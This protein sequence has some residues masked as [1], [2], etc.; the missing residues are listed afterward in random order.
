MEN[1]CGINFVRE[2]VP[3]KLE[4]IEEGEKKGMVRVHAQYQDGTPY[5]DVFNTVMFAVGRQAE[6]E[7]LGLG[8]VGVTLNPKNKKISSS[9]KSRKYENQ[10]EFETRKKYIK[11]DDKSERYETVYME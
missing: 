5:E 2:C 11:N 8:A 6:T 1:K 9:V 4:K 3:T 10:Q 7:K